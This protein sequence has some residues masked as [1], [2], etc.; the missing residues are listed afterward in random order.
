[1]CIRDRLQT[2]TASDCAKKLDLKVNLPDDL[3]VPDIN[4]HIGT[5]YLSWLLD[6]YEGDISLAKM[7]IRDRSYSKSF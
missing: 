5:Y 7:C 4:I 2:E 3:Y 6:K 1:M